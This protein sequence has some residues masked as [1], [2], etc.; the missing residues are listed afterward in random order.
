VHLP[1][2]RRWIVLFA[3]LCQVLAGTFAHVPVA[4]AAPSEGAGK[5]CPDQVRA[6]TS[7]DDEIQ[8]HARNHHDGDTG[9]NGSHGCQDGHCKCPCAHVPA[10]PGGFSLPAAAT[11]HLPVLT[12]YVPPS[13]PLQPIVFFRPPI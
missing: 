2:Y 8:A 3:L 5:H 12:V 9:T 4:S 10:V 7:G 13:L 6:A 11:P 1:A